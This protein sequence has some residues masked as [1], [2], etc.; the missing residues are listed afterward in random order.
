MLKCN[1]E[2]YVDYRLRELTTKIRK[3]PNYSYN[4]DYE[5]GTEFSNP[6][7]ESVFNEYQVPE[8]EEFKNITKKNVKSFEISNNAYSDDFF[9]NEL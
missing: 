6:S 4:D 1:Y 5:V 7:K 9:S 3:S 2:T 8:K